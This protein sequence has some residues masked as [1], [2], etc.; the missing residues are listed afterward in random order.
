MLGQWGSSYA[1]GDVI[2]TLHDG[3]PR[4]AVC[5]AHTG[6]GHH[7]FVYLTHEALP[8][9]GPFGKSTESRIT[10]TEELYHDY[11]NGP[12]VAHLSPLDM[13]NLG[14]GVTLPTIEVTLSFAKLA[15]MISEKM[16]R[17]ITV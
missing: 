8:G 11:W 17:V 15:E 3:T 10:S 2:F 7:Q 13:L 5:I 1:N 6:D 9:D 16:P 12:K 4:L 14:S